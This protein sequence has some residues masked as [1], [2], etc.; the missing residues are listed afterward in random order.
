[1]ATSGR[2]GYVVFA[3][4]TIC[5]VNW[6]ITQNQEEIDVTSFCSTGDYKEFVLGFK[7]A[8]G[9]FTTVDCYDLFSSAGSITLGSDEGT[10]S[11]SIL[12]NGQEAGVEIDGRFEETFNFR[13]TG[14]VTVSCS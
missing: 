13:F 3:N 11:G 10:F 14:P 6:S 1:M 5:A 8:T 2:T 7:D 4:S 9:S 12:V